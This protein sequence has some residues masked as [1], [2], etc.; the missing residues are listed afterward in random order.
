[1][2]HSQQN[3]YEII[4]AKKYG[5]QALYNKTIGFEE[6]PFQEN[7]TYQ[8]LNKYN[9]RY[10]SITEDGRYVNL[11]TIFNKEKRREINENFKSLQSV[12]LK[13]SKLSTPAILSKEINNTLGSPIEERKGY[14]QVSF[15]FIVKADNGDLYGFIYRSSSMGM[16]Y[17]YKKEG[18]IWKE[19]AKLEIWI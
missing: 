18:N 1:M 14:M 6:L 3:L 11:D 7:F 13:K 2:S 17:I 12:K 19:F 4:E 16:L 8:I 10:N 15:P 5:E 9:V